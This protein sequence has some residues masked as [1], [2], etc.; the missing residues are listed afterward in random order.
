MNKHNPAKKRVN[1]LQIIWLLC[2]CGLSYTEMDDSADSSLFFPFLLL[3]S[4]FCIAR[5][6]RFLP[7]SWHETLAEHMR[8][9]IVR[10]RALH[11]RQ[12]RGKASPVLSTRP[13]TCKNCGEK[14][15]GNFC[16]RCGQS[17]NTPR[18]YL[19]DALGNVL[20]S[21]FRVDGKFAHT[22][23]NLSYRP[24]Y[25]IKDFI[26]GRRIHYTMPFPTVF[27]LTAFYVLTVQLIVPEIKSKEKEKETAV[28]T[29]TRM[30]QAQQ[31]QVAIDSLEQKKA[32]IKSRSAQLGMEITINELKKEQRK[33]EKAGTPYA[34]SGFQLDNELDKAHGRLKAL[35]S[36]APF[37]EHVVDL[38]KKWGHGNKALRIL[39]TLPVL[40][41]AT[42]WA[43]YRRKHRAAYNMMEHIFIQAYIAAQILLLSIIVVPFNG[44]AH[45]DDLYEV[46]FWFIFFLFCWDYRQIFQYTWEKTFWKTTLMFTYCLSLVIGIAVLGVLA[47]LLVNRI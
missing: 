21:L 32:Q 5:K 36:Q 45:V 28:Q 13:C 37:L 22:L 3:F 12:I 41:V 29:D 27:L 20:K 46:P 33:M 9:L 35:I 31:M 42:R 10:L 26:R 17:R 18:Y 30:S 8:P 16:P 6:R 14:Y 23:I 44:T 24:G 39:L 47:L 11:I 7:V 25:M 43:F 15:T 1:T 19:K 4:I 2:L 34:E 38:L 40:A